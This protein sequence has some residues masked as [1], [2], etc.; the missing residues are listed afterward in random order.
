MRAL[1]T[2]KTAD[3]RTGGRPPA[4]TPLAAPSVPTGEALSPQ[5]LMALQ[6]SVGNA[7]AVQLVRQAGQPPVQR[8]AAADAPIQRMPTKA[9]T[10]A[11]TVPANYEQSRAQFQ[12]TDNVPVEGVPTPHGLTNLLINNMEN[13]TCGRDVK[14]LL[15]QMSTKKWCI[16]AGV[17]QGGLGGNG[18]GA[19]PNIHITLDVGGKGWHVQLMSNDQLLGVTGG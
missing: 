16:T 7:V 17:H 18:R 9:A 1:D 13:R 11:T 4:R 14:A 10:Y 8:S 3:E 19:D 5:T 15:S 2:A 6:R 12:G